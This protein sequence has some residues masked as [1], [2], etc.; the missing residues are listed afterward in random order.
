MVWEYEIYRLACQ[1]YNGE[2]SKLW[3]RLLKLKRFSSCWKLTKRKKK[4]AKI[5]QHFAVFFSL[6]RAHKGRNF[7]HFM[8]RLLLRDAKKKNFVGKF[9]RYIHLQRKINLR[10]LKPFKILNTLMK[11]DEI[12]FNYKLKRKKRPKL[13]I[14]KRAVAKEMNEDKRTTRRFGLFKLFSFF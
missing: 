13:L 8:S 14:I 5:C 11:Y 12:N 3:R 10:A 1:I 6:F 9:S 2:L 7:F 4:I